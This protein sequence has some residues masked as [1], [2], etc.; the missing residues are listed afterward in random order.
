MSIRNQ[1]AHASTAPRKER[2]YCKELWPISNAACNR[3]NPLETTLSLSPKWK[4]S[5]YERE[6]RS[7][8]SAASTAT[9]LRSHVRG[10][11][12]EVKP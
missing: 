6:N 1:R 7:C 11:I 10:Q 3:R 9:L 12:A 4:R 8:I 5:W 2:Q